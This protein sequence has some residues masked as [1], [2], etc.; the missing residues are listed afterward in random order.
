MGVPRM[1]LFAAFLGD[2]RDLDDNVAELLRTPHAFNVYM[3]LLMEFHKEINAVKKAFY[4]R[5][6]ANK[7]GDKQA[8]DLAKMGISEV[9][10]SSS[11][12]SSSVAAGEETVSEGVEYDGGIIVIF[13]KVGSITCMCRCFED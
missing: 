13:V 8:E 12:T 6:T 9:E 7:P 2:G 11:A 5:I 3:T 1:R 10:E 4:A